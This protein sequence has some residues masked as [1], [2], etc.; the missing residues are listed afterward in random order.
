MRIDR[1]YITC[2]LDDS[3]LARICVASIR[4]FHPDI[5]I[6]LI[7][8]ESQRR[9]D[10]RVMEVHYGVEVHSVQRDYAGWGFSTFSRL[11]YPP[12][13]RA[14]FLDAD[15]VFVG[16][17]LD[18]LEHFDED[19]VVCGDHGPSDDYIG[20]S[21]F[22][23]RGLRRLDPH[24]PRPSFVFNTGQFVC[25]TGALTQESM[26]SL[27]TFGPPRLRYP[28]IFRCADQ[29]ILNYVVHS[30]AQQGS[31]TL[32]SCPFMV[33]APNAGAAGV[34]SP[35]GI[36]RPLLI[37]WAGPKPLRI[38]KMA[39]HGLLKYFEDM[40]Y[41]QLPFGNLRRRLNT[42]TRIAE[43]LARLPVSRLRRLAK[44]LLLR[45]RSSSS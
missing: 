45:A 17:V 11:L 16:P 36:G 43:R 30:L 41:S 14:L 35:A 19:F 12:K 4:H 2:C 27:V 39:C 24:F 8:D 9:F 22:D 1:I 29:G 33:W 21:F 15:I 5:P 34:S 31:I 26:E 13:E 38:R 37:H 7:K 25:N 20:R 18:R 10:T 6:T 32:A 40:Y 3:H 42:A 23:L 28:D 44:R